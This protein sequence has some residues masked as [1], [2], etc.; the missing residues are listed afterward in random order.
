MWLK[1]I[2]NKYVLSFLGIVAIVYGIYTVS[3]N[4]TNTYNERDMLR[5]EVALKKIKITELEEQ[6]TIC[7][8]ERIKNDE[9]CAT[10]IN[11][12]GELNN[13]HN[14]ILTALYSCENVKYKPVE[15]GKQDDPNTVVYDATNAIEFL[16]TNGLM[17]EENCPSKSPNP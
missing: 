15:R 7:N 14:K 12:I 5:T 13:R 10:Y 1:L 6:L 16:C 8:Q 17:Q 9:A 2:T 11:D 4:V 3:K